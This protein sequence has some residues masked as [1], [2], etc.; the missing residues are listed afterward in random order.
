[1]SPNTSTDLFTF[2]KDLGGLQIKLSR[3]ILCSAKGPNVPNSRTKYQRSKN[4]FSVTVIAL[5]CAHIFAR[6]LQL[7]AQSLTGSPG[8]LVAGTRPDY[9]ANHVQ[10]K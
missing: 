3:A 9:L 2:P 1:M 5:S 10:K 7:F 4:V 8:T 6:L